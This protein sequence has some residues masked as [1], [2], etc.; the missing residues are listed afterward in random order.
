[1]P[2]SPEFSFTNIGGQGAEQDRPTKDK[3]VAEKSDIQPSPTQEDEHSVSY[4]GVRLE[5]AHVPSDFVP[6]RE[7]YTDYIEDRFALELEQK[8]AVGFASGDPSLVEGGTS[9]GK[10]TTVRKMCAE[11]GWEVHYANL[12][13]ATDVED[14]MGRYIPNPH[15]TKPDDPEFVFADGKVT[16]GL[17]KEEGKTKV[18]ILDEFNAAAP[19]IVIR[20]HEVLDAMERSGEV[21]LSEDAS[22]SVPV[23]KQQTKIIA[24]TNPPG[25]GYFGREPLDPAQLRRWVYLKEASNLPESTFSFSTKALFG[26]ETGTE[27][28]P[29][30]AYLQSKDGLMS[31]EQIAEIPGMGELEAKYEEF[32]K[33][34]NELLRLRKV[35]ADQPQQFTFDDRMEPRRVRDFVLRFYNGDINETFQRALRYYYSNKLE[36]SEDRQQL[37]ELIS[38]VAYVPQPDSRR[39][40]LEAEARAEKTS[41]KGKVDQELADLMADP[42]IP[43]SVKEALSSGEAKLSADVLEQMKEAR[44]IMGKG[45]MGPEEIKTAFDFEPAPSTIPEIPFDRSELQR[46]AELGQMLVLRVGKT[47]DGKPMTMDKIRDILSN[48]VKDGGKVLYNTDW[49]KDE[50]FFKDEQI[51]P[52]WALTSTE[53]IPSSTNKNYLEQTEAIVDYLKSEVF[54]GKPLPKEYQDAIAQFE[55][56]KAEI[57]SL[58]DSDWK[59]AAEK[60]ESLSITQMTRQTPAEAIYDLIMAYQNNEE[61]LLPDMYTWTSRRDSDGDL[62]FVGS[63]RSDGVRVSS[64]DPGNRGGILGV[65]FSRSL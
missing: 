61:R 16:A 23:S 58:I 36:S 13:G 45:F 59:A 39:L 38:H 41:L 44:E 43:D 20:L 33:A 2:S 35:G 19:N 12:N 47:V 14:L 51:E 1:M 30:E 56:Q 11:L 4:L 64:D 18:I 37:E 26:L 24:L 55:G 5:K 40:G 49:Y 62:V 9:I 31:P 57:S 27:T 17:R 8:I 25:K 50:A 54:A 63:F 42:T 52:C 21:V 28:V 34:A 53:V 48:K 60:L 7:K 46:A 15:R 3:Q 32:H 22:E 29:Q 10:T 6:D 65:S